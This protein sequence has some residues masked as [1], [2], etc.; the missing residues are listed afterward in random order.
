MV[1]SPKYVSKVNDPSIF[2]KGSKQVGF[3]ESSPSFQRMAGL[4]I[5]DNI[6][7]DDELSGHGN[8]S[9]IDN[10]MSGVHDDFEYVVH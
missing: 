1:Y 8:G 9:N 10:T 6:G 7:G 3:K 2:I 5:R 4:T